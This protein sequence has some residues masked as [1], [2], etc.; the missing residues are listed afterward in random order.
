[1]D[2]LSNQAAEMDI[3]GN[4]CY[5]SI[6]SI[7]HL[8]TE[9]LDLDDDGSDGADAEIGLEIALIEVSKMTQIQVF[10]PN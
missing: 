2:G 10:Y 1:M 3:D 7:D 5:L 4:V 9:R 8:V 6:E